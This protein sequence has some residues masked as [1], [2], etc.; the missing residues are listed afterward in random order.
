MALAVETNREADELSARFVRDAVPLVDQLFHVA[1]RYTRNHADAE[2]LV[3]EVVLKAYR[4]FQ[5]FSDGA[6]IRA[7]LFRIM[8]NT[9]IDHYRTA[10]RRPIELLTDEVA[11]A[12]SSTGGRHPWLGSPSAELRA[13]ESLGDDEVKEAMRA[14]PESQRMAIFYAD[15]EGF[16]YQEVAFVLQVPV[17]TVTSRLHRGR[18]RLRALLA[19]K[20]AAKG[21][22]QNLWPA[23]QGGSTSG[24]R[25]VRS[26]G[27]TTGSAPKDS[28]I[29]TLVFERLRKKTYYDPRMSNPAFP[30]AR[31]HS[32]VRS[33]QNASGISELSC[34]KSIIR[35]TVWSLEAGQATTK[36]G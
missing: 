6:N 33:S 19:D 3:Q 10:Q 12:Q 25:V 15:V 18:R 22:R 24:R 27:S 26:F 28:Q 17:G 2:D 32:A 34:T 20:A 29:T 36:A 35:S 14:L 31:L 8:T 1:Y 11:D 9:W 16:R 4:N 13:L 21:Y 7:W 23:E 5:Q 30:G